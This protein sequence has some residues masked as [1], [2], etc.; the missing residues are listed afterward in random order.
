MKQFKKGDPVL[1]KDGNRRGK[2]VN[3]VPIEN[4]SRLSQPEDKKY[5]YDVETFD[6]G[7]VD[8]V[9]GLLY[10][11]LIWCPSSE[12]KTGRRLMMSLPQC[13]SS[14]TSGSDLSLKVGDVVTVRSTRRKVKIIRVNEK[15]QSYTAEE[16]N[17]SLSEYFRKDLESEIESQERLDRWRK[18]EL[19]PKYFTDQ[20]VRTVSREDL[21]TILIMA[22]EDIKTK[23]KRIAELER[24]LNDEPSSEPVS[25]KSKKN[26]LQIVSKATLQK[27]LK[28]VISCVD[29]P[30]S[31]LKSTNKR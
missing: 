17:E 2:I 6:G 1:I 5:M 12:K 9:I 8:T 25:E 10:N 31:G 3:V 16:E 29:R 11:D 18:K 4:V 22:G 7:V 21:E 19:L 24:E 28:N 27:T 14:T 23:D 13:L 26:L 15:Y 30:Y 20:F